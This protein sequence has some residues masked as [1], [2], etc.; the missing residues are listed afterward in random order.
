M[1]YACTSSGA[2]HELRGG[3]QREL[4]EPHTTPSAGGKAN[5]R[6]GD[7]QAQCS[8]PSGGGSSSGSS[9]GAYHVV[10][11]A[12]PRANQGRYLATT[13]LSL[14]LSPVQPA[15]LTLLWARHAP[16]ATA[17]AAA[18]ERQAK[19]DGGT[20]AGAHAQEPQE[21]QEDGVG[22]VSRAAG[23]RCAMQLGGACVMWLYAKQPGE[24]GSAVS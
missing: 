24:G 19:G 21:E 2:A 18:D 3:T 11:L 7:P 9:S 5:P 23:L 12:S 22:G 17:P 6:A 1:T 4:Q 10:V 8:C 13:L 14:A 15:S 20:G 16:H